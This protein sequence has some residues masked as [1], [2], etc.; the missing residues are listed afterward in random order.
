MKLFN[1]SNKKDQQDKEIQ[2][3]VDYLQTENDQL[4][5]QVESLKLDLSEFKEENERLKEALNRS[6]FRR[7]LIKMGIG[8]AILVVSYILL[9]LVGERNTNL[10]WILLIEAA[11]IFF[12][13]NRGESK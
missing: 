6:Q 5:N 13:L 3:Q 9:V 4:L 10:P 1:W 11:F 7:G 8:M 2:T 12:M